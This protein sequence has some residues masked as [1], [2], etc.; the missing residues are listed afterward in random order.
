MQIEVSM[1]YKNIPGTDLYPSS[2]CL[3]TALIGSSIDSS[4]S[5]KLLDSYLD[6]GGNFI[7]TAHI[8]AY[9]VKG[10]SLSERTIG[11]WIMERG[12]RDKILIATKGGISTDGTVKLGREEI[13]KDL[14]ESLK[15]LRTD[16]IDLYWLHRDDPNY[17]VSNILEILNDQMEKGK[18]RYFGCSNWD[19]RRIEEAICYASRNKLACFVGNQMMWSLAIPN[20]EA[21]TD[22][23]LVIMDKNGIEFHKRRLF[24]AIPYSSQANGFFTKLSKKATL[25]DDIKKIYLNNENM[26]RLKRVQKLASELSKSVTEISLAYLTSQPF[27]TIPI[28][29]C[30]TVEQITES[31]GAGDL[32]LQ[33][34]MITYLEKG[35]TF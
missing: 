16:Y 30:R 24:T 9:W 32:I 25:N 19:V 2:I 15:Y 28:V 10:K 3:G 22:K 33:E 21:I 13:I 35:T 11:K 6:L 17:P 5:F 8:Y 18:I 31:I 26:K 23:T 29:G 34:D 1:I 20:V 7:D 27:T 14:N 4:S 12:I